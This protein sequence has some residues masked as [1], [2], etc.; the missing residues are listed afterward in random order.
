MNK[1]K[2]GQGVF[3]MSFSTIFSIIIIVFIVLVAF[4]AIRHFVGLSKCTNVGLYYDDL[5]EEVRDAWTSTSGRYQ[6][7]FTAKI[8]TKGM[9]ASGI[10]YVCFG[11]LSGQPTDDDATR[12]Q[13]DL[14][15]E[16]YYDPTEDYNVFM[17][18]PDSSCD[19]RLG[20]IVLECGSSDC[21]T[22]KVDGT[23][24]FFCN[25]I[26]DDGTVSV[27]LYKQPTDYKITLTNA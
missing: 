24:Q 16:Y 2:K 17:Y 3:G 21:V 20:A 7:D 8:P 9:F 19:S 22:T 5:R 10:K 26:A 18:P 13:Q 12:I 27:H 1:N 25:P 11:R 23:E 14:E 15:L 6:D 4:L